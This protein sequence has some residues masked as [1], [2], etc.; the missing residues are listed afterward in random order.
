M[1]QMTI[2]RGMLA[3]ALLILT[4]A[5]C[6]TKGN[7]ED[8]EADRDQVRGERDRLA[9]EVEALASVN[10]ELGRDLEAKE[11]EVAALTVDYDG[12]VGEL[13]TEVVS[14]Q[15]EIQQLI[16]GIRMKVSDELL[17]ASGST[18]L[19]V[20]GKD[21]LAKVAGQIKGGNAIISVEGHSDDVRVGPTLRKRYPT[22]WELAGARAA[23]IVRLLSE[24][25]VDPSQLR[26]VSRGP[27]APIASNESEEGRAQNRRSEIIVRPIPR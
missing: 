27:F 12:L 15:I 10:L 3:C 23:R 26:A 13:E 25:G 21:L 18:T 5:G 19:S 16:D 20:E 4:S 8:M 17:F 1:R 9:G 2:G 7:Y 24:E 22:N 11:T 6:V 14:G